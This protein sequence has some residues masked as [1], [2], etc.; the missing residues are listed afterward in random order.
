M[1]VVTAAAVVMTA[2]LQHAAWPLNDECAAAGMLIIPGTRRHDPFPAALIIHRA[3]YFQSATCDPIVDIKL[4]VARI[5]VA[6][7]IAVGR[8]LNLRCRTGQRFEQFI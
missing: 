7:R 4:A 2:G 8:F 3:V 1:P 5:P 6:A